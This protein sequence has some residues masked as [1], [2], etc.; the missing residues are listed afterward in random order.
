MARGALEL[1]LDSFAVWLVVIGLL[2][3]LLLRVALA[4][5]DRPWAT[6]TVCLSSTAEQ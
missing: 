1:E 6:L 4:A 3:L 2:L 5:P